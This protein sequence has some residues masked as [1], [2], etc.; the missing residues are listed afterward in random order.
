MPEQK[1]MPI[2]LI[3]VIL[4]IIGAVVLWRTQGPTGP[5]PTVTGGS[6]VPFDSATTD[7][8]TVPTS[9]PDQK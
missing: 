1:Q 7:A 2:G 8:V 6:A 9:T 5:A 4:L 3:V